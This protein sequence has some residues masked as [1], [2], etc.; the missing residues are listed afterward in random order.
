MALADSIRQFLMGLQTSTSPG[1]AGVT[2]VV[3][4][5]AAAVQPAINRSYFLRGVQSTLQN[6]GNKLNQPVAQAANY[7]PPQRPS[8][9]PTQGVQQ[10]AQG[11][12]TSIPAPSPAASRYAQPV[13]QWFQN[14]LQEAPLAKAVQASA[15]TNP[16][17]GLA[18]MT[19]AP[20]ATA[21]IPYPQ[22]TAQQQRDYLSGV[23]A[24]S[25]PYATMTGSLQAIGRGLTVPTQTGYSGQRF[26]DDLANA[27]GR[28]DFISA[29]QIVDAIPFNSPYKL[30]AENML[31]SILGR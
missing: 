23:A 22:M 7:S 1:G 28:N 19:G 25:L 8:V 17:V 6:A 29:R 16:Q 27:I 5:A 3:S 12:R 15:T 10:F 30:Q 9:T 11:V 20:A 18:V 31:R 4:G 13:I 14:R 21:T 24:N 26:L 2:P